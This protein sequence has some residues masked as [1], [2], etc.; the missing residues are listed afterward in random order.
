MA[1]IE[2]NPTYWDKFRL[3]F[4]YICF[5]K[6]MNTRVSF[7]AKIDIKQE[8]LHKSTLGHLK[9]KENMGDLQITILIH[10]LF[11]MA[12]FQYVQHLIFC[13]FIR[14]HLLKLLNHIF[15]REGFSA[16]KTMNDQKLTAVHN[17]QGSRFRVSRK[18]CKQQPICK[19]IQIQ[20]NHNKLPKK[21]LVRIAGPLN[22]VK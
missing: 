20:L 12:Y 15:F 18:A 7:H 2:A 11:W 6:Y 14:L 5:R 13:L 17:K 19:I 22:I 8:K 16:T 3:L 1:L 21:S 4:I 9:A 10:F